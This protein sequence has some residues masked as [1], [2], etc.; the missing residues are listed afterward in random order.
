MARLLFSVIFILSSA[1]LSAQNIVPNPSFQLYDTCPDAAGEVHYCKYWNVANNSTPDYFTTCTANS[2]IS[3]PSNFA[4]YQNAPNAYVGVETYDEGGDW[5]EYVTTSIPALTIGATYKVSLKLSFGDK[6]EYK[7]VP[8]Q[9]FFHI[10]ASINNT[11]SHIAHDPQIDFS[12][13]GVFDDTD[14]VVISR[15]FVPDSAYTHIVIGSFKTDAFSSITVHDPAA[16]A[17]NI[18]YYYLDSV[19][20]EKQP[21]SVTS[22]HRSSSVTAYPNPFSSQTHLTFP[23]PYGEKHTLYVYNILGVVVRKI[24]DIETNS[25]TLHREGLA[26]GNYYYSLHAPDGNTYRGALIIR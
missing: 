22:L 23:N 16:P 15:N 13:L 17:Y 7:T 24:E 1:I 10:N 4:G 18:A 25:V 12:D 14:W 8:P 19:S 20:V 3:I 11:P 26:N 5:R 2:Y 9:I 21:V 6:C